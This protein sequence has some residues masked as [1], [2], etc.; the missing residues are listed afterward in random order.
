MA[1]QIHPSKRERFR[2]RK[3]GHSFLMLPHFVI[4]SPQWRALSGNAIKF[5]VELASA[6][7]GSNTGDLSLTR[8]QALA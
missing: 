8:K 4:Q 5:L 7:D 1:K 3:N 6:Y 2:G